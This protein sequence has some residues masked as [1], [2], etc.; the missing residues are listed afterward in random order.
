[1]DK[2]SL[3]LARLGVTVGFD[4]LPF[5][6][7]VDKV[8]LM[9]VLLTLLDDDNYDYDRAVLEQY[10]NPKQKQQQKVYRRLVVPDS[11][12]DNR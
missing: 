8:E 9:K 1:M 12:K 4:K 3:E 7:Q 10:G 6:N 11:D 5:K 2:E